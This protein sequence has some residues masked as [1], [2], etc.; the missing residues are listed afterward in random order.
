MPCAWSA[1]GHVRRRLHAGHQQQPRT[2]LPSGAGRTTNAYQSRPLSS[3][4]A[5]LMLR[6]RICHQGRV[7][8]PAILRRQAMN[9]SAVRA[10]QADRELLDVGQ[11]FLIGIDAADDV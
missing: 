3:S 11:A 2:A 4:Y 6:I 5:S 10:E 7:A 9:L 1:A 8:K